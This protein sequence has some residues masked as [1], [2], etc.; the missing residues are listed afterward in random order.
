MKFFKKEGFTEI[1][2]KIDLLLFADD[3]IILD[4]NIVNIQN[5]LLVLEKYC[6]YERLEVNLSKSK[7]IKFRK[8]GRAKKERKVNYKDEFLEVVK[9]YTYF[10]V[11][12]SSNGS[13]KLAVDNALTKGKAALGAIWQILCNGRNTNWLTARKLFDA[14]VTSVVPY[15]SG[16]WGL[17]T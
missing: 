13:I 12:L 8:S 16:V 17:N 14:M 7:I 15:G 10:G 4:K 11:I 1:E 6:D 9:Q 5:K 2:D 3:L